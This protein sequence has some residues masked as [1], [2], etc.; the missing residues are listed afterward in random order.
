MAFATYIVRGMRGH[1]MRFALVVTFVALG[2]VMYQLGASLDNAFTAPTQA[3]H[4]DRLLVLN[5]VSPQMPLPM[6]YAERIAT[7]KGVAMVTHATWMGAFFRHPGWMVPAIAVDSDTFFTVNRSLNVASGEFDT[8][9][10]TRDGVLIDRRFA[11]LYKLSVG[12][13]LPLQTSIW[14]LDRG[15]I[16]DLRVVGTVVDD[17]AHSRPAVYLHYEYLDRSRLS[18]QGLTSYFLVRP[19]SGVDGA[20]LG[21]DI[22]ATFADQVFQGITQTASIQLHMKLLASRLFDFGR[23]VTF[24]NVCVCALLSILLAS[25]LYVVAQKSLADYR[26]FYWLGFSRHWVLCMAFLQLASYVVVGIV[27]GWLVGAVAVQ[28]VS[29]MSGPALISF[30]VSTGDHIRLVL[31]GVALTVITI[32]PVIGRLAFTRLS[33]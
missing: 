31:I 16:L 1:R 3:E 8:W 7:V 29:K 12:D 22:D 33:R 24:A 28:L 23:A 5:G 21:R 4:D 32:L 17:D 11:D 9:V 30:G 27:L 15:G 26:V 10:S 13:R 2:V 20:A 19:V 18:G 6:R 25:N 14:Q